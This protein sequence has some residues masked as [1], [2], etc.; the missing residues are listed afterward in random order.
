MLDSLAYVSVVRPT[1]LTAL[2]TH[3]PG[4]VSVSKTSTHDGVFMHM[5]AVQIDLRG[6]HVSI[7]RVL[8]CSYVLIWCAVLRLFHLPDE[9]SADPLLY[10]H[11]LPCFP[12]PSV[13]FFS[14]A[15]LLTPAPPTFFRPPATLR[16]PGAML[17]VNTAQT[18]R[19]EIIPAP[20][21]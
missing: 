17:A 7:W 1:L 8:S 12:A 11:A 15:T 10:K 14:P 4:T 2:Q 20:K 5:T 19:R 21:L 16:R 6:C 9:S 18:K 3:L 13:S